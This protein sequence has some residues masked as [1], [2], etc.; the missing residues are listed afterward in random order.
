MSNQFNGEKDNHIAYLELYSQ[1]RLSANVD[2]ED[3]DFYDQE[4]IDLLLSQKQNW[5]IYHLIGDVM[6]N[7]DLALKLSSNLAHQIAL[8]VDQEPTFVMP[9]P[10]KLKPNRAVSRWQRF[11]PTL[12]MAAAVASVVWVARP[13]IEQM[14]GTQSTPYFARANAPSLADSA[15]LN[16]YVRAHRDLSGPAVVQTRPSLDEVVK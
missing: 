1:E 7:P 8:R 11:W 14:Q 5:E 12:A 2:A 13:V 15:R 4:G 9:A 10:A 3:V 6:R 16:S